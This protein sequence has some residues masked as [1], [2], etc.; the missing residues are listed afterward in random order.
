M[1]EREYRA[2]CGEAPCDAAAHRQ[3]RTTGL[4]GDA[5]ATPESRE[6]ISKVAAQENPVKPTRRRPPAAQS[7]CLLR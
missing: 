6:G 7:P 5:G 3:R 1:R 2:S 4:E